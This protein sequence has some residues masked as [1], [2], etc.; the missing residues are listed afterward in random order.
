MFDAD[1]QIGGSTA[2]RRILLVDDNLPARKALAQLLKREGYDTTSVADGK[3]AL[4]FLRTSAPPDVIVTDMILPD[5]DGRE[6]GIVA[7]GLSPRPWV[8]LV[9]G[10]GR[11]TETE[12]LSPWGIDQLFLKPVD[13]RSLLAAL[14]DL[15]IDTPA[16][17]KPTL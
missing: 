11:E 12:D 14:R 2:K 3:S 7:R 5:F 17:A 8:I 10:W 9:T 16:T 4:E 6:L 13:F 1:S 15:F